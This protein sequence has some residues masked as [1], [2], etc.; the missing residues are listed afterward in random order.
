MNT[1]RRF[2][3]MVFTAALLDCDG[4]LRQEHLA[5]ADRLRR[6][7]SAFQSAAV[8]TIGELWAWPSVLKL[9]LVEH[10]RA[11]ADLLKEGR[12]LPSAAPD[13]GASGSR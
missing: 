2:R 1:D 12:S 6:F 10:L 5:D 7:V 8:L 11:R 13:R 9:G 3:R 4:G